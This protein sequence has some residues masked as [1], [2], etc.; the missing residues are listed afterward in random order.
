MSEGQH[1][2][3]KKLRSL[4]NLR[5]LP[6]PPSPHVI[7]YG[8]KAVGHGHDIRLFP[9]FIREVERK[10]LPPPPNEG[11][12]SCYFHPH[13]AAQ[14]V[15]ELSGR[16]ICNLCATTWEGKTVSL[17]ALQT[18]LQG[19]RSTNKMKWDDL[20]LAL[21]IWPNL[22]CF[23]TILT[24]PIALVICLL[25]WREGPTGLLRRSRW[26]YVVAALLALAEITLWIVLFTQIAQ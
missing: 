22:L 25:K 12:S 23:G 5:R 9:A 21:V 14:T 15:C 8:R 18:H 24:A 3:Q 26:R 6:L 19:D 7:D 16:L 11:E 4:K 17:D 2:Y 13:Y 10:E 20:A 1:L